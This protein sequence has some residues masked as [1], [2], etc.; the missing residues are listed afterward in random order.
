MRRADAEGGIGRCR[1]INMKTPNE[2]L[3]LNCAC[4]RGAVYIHEP[5]RLTRWRRI[6]GPEARWNQAVLISQVGRQNREPDRISQAAIDHAVTIERIHADAIERRR[7]RK[8]IHRQI[9]SVGPHTELRIITEKG[10]V[11][12]VHL[13]R[14]QPPAAGNRIAGF[15]DPNTLPE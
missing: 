14:V 4:S 6:A 13:Y 1:K 11:S 9:V 12:R 2:D 8:F 10:R 7:A 3:G 15:A 5:L